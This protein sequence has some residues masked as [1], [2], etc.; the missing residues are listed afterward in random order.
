[1]INQIKTLI[2]DK[3]PSTVRKR[4]LVSGIIFIVLIALLAFVLPWDDILLVLR[5]SDLKMVAIGYLITTPTLYLNA[6]SFKV[7]TDQQKMSLSAFRIMAINMIVSFYEIFIPATLFGSGLRWYRISKSSNRPVQSFTAIAYYKL[8]NI[9]LTLLLS[10]GFL[11]LTDVETIRG[12]LVEIILVMAAIAAILL[13]T[14][15]LSKIMVVRLPY[16]Q[17]RLPESHLLEYLFKAAIKILTSFSEF[18][19]LR[20]KHQLWIIVLS[21]ASQAVY[22]MG[23]MVMAESVG[24][25]ISFTKLGVIRSISLLAAS[26]PINFTPAIGLNDISLV[27]LLTAYGVD[28]DFAVAMSV[29]VLVRKILF[30]LLGGGIEAV[31]FLLKKCPIIFRSS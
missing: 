23:Y 28:L 20:L 29:V 31:E 7:I 5:N 13:L 26:L 30:S 21:L 14:P 11:I 22:L 17:E 8:V 19:S 2:Y 9:F 3:S 6:L 24:I 16:I 25:S 4:Q 1:M 12:N 10:F 18:G 15:A 27:A